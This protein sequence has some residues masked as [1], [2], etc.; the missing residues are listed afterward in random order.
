MV[1]QDNTATIV[2]LLVICLKKSILLL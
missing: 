2:H 1:F